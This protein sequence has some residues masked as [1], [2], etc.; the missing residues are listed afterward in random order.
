MCKHTS[1]CCA[2]LHPD[3]LSD[4]PVHKLIVESAWLNSHELYVARSIVT[5]SVT[6]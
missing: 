2:V 4:Q 6:G 3:Q 5:T 1:T